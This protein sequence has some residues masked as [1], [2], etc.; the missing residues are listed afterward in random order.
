MME[1]FAAVLDLVSS[2]K[3]N[4]EDMS[5]K[6]SICQSWASFFL[7]KIQTY[8]SGSLV[9]LMRLTMWSLIQRSKWVKNV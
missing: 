6:V 9:R 2:H 4:D 3:L 5:V 7:R 8:S 1:N